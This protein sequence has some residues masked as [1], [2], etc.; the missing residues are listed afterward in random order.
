[1]NILVLGSGG[2][3]HAIC[4]ALKQSSSLKKIWCLPGNAGTL[5]ICNKATNPKL[6]FKS[7]LSF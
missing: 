1:M 3:E 5:T 7:I 2:R 4:Y 6:D